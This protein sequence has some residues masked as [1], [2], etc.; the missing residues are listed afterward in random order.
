MERQT[1]QQFLSAYPIS[2]LVTV[3]SAKGSTPREAGAFVLVSDTA[4]YKTIGGGQLE[5]MAIDKARLMLR[6]GDS[7]GVMEIGLGPEIGQCCGGRVALK[8]QRVDKALAH[9]IIASEQ[10]E[11]DALPHVYVFG[12]GHVGNALCRAL[13]L[14]PLRTIL[15]DTRQA[16]LE[17]APEGIETH[18]AAMPE[19][20]V[21]QAPASSAFL[22]LT[23]DHALDFLILKEALARP[24]A[25]YVG[26]IGSRTKRGT[27]NS[28]FMREG[29]KKA[30]L[31]RLVCPLGGS[32]VKDKR[33]EVIAALTA[34]EVTMAL[35]KQA[36]RGAAKADSAAFPSS[37]SHG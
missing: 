3:E 26:M 8:L 23:H 28:W 30:A 6:T 27:F 25:A 1:A 10:G 24:D 32:A 22:V 29:G 34:A 19:D 17:A 11:L 20:L 4:I 12:A 21:R 14:L 18:L 9:E 7:E 36:A 2:V 37:R 33:P 31:A 13:S 16:E 5:Y 15:V 35:V